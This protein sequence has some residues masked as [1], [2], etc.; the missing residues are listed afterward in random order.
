MYYT[1]GAGPRSGVGATHNND[2]GAQPHMASLENIYIL[3]IKH[4][5][6]VCLQNKESSV[7][8]GFGHRS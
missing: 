8:F 5:S 3:F 1:M 4:N 7:V 2:S 6:A